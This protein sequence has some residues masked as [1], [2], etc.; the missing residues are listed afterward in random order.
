MAAVTQLGTATFDTNSGTHT[1]TAT[2]AVGDLIVIIT[3]STGNTSA[4]TPTDDQGGTYVRVAT[5]VKAT[6]ADTLGI[7]I[8]TSLISSAVSTVFTHAPGTSTGGGLVVLKV[9]GMTQ[10][11]SA[12]ARSTGVQSNQGIAIP[13]PV[14]NNTPLSSNPIIG[15]FFNAAN[16]ATVTQRTGYAEHVDIGYASPTT[17]LETMSLDSG[18]T[19]ATIAWG[20]SETT[21][22]DAAVEL[23][24]SAGGGAAPPTLMLTGVG[25]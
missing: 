7:H 10:T 21:F 3:A 18:E 5:S 13:S 16:P 20:S 15:A 9:T 4:A 19:S 8:R 2:P 22:C 25:A 1:V 6:S 11:G 23:D 17:G 24:S 12:A 14:L